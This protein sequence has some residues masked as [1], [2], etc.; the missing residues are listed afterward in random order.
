LRCNKIL[1]LLKLWSVVSCQ[2]CNISKNLG[3]HVFWIGKWRPKREWFSFSSISLKR[4]IKEY[5][6]NA[7]SILSSAYNTSTRYYSF[8]SSKLQRMNLTRLSTWFL[9]VPNIRVTDRNE[10]WIRYVYLKMPTSIQWSCKM[11]TILDGIKNILPSSKQYFF[12]VANNIQIFLASS[13]FYRVLKL[14]IIIFAP[15]YRSSEI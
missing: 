8:F 12:V 7:E 3:M 11:Q 13:R 9:Q 14:T 2:V 6:R 10:K 1:K 4:R 5:S 15:F